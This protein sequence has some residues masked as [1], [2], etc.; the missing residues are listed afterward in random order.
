MEYESWL[1]DLVDSEASKAFVT[2]KKR[3]SRFT[4]K[5]AV[6]SIGGVVHRG[7][8]RSSVKVDEVLKIPAPLIA[9]LTPEEAFGLL[10][11]PIDFR[12]NWSDVISSSAAKLYFVLS[13]CRRTL[14]SRMSEDSDSESRW[15]LTEKEFEKLLFSSG[16]DWMERPQIFQT[17]KELDLNKSGCLHVSELCAVLQAAEEICK[18]ILNGLCDPTELKAELTRLRQSKRF[19][20]SCSILNML[21]YVIFRLI[22]SI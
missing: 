13:H 1:K 16:V 19:E 20:A 7:R 8:S 12:P 22:L 21:S 10:A 5:D 14:D 11:P 3:G 6:F 17:Y 18:D 4:N 2:R 15:Y 9:S